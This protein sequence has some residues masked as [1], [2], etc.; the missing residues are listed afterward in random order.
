MPDIGIF[1]IALIGIIAIVVIKPDEWPS[2]LRKIGHYYGTA[3][4]YLL[5]AKSQSRQLYDDIT[6]LADPAQLTS[7]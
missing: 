2:L 6:K 3:H 4:R 1:E 7:P 5:S